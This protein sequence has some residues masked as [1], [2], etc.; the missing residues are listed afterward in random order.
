MPSVVLMLNVKAPQTT[1]SSP[2]SLDV[3]GWPGGIALAPLLPGE[4]EAEYAKLTARFLAAAKPRDFIEEI[5][6]RDAVDLSWEILR[7]RRQKAGLL[8]MACSAGVRSVAKELGFKGL[9]YDFAAKWMSGD[10]KTRKQFDEMLKKAGLGMED[11]TAEALSSKVDS[12]ERVDR[13]LASA[14]A[15]RNNAL[16]EIDRHREALCAAMRQ[17]IDEV[18]DAEFRD[19]ET[20]EVSRGSPS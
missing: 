7:L 1:S 13:I 20:G 16:R 5:L 11:V 4:S 2:G 6:A 17:A 15:R 18:Q 9:V 3:S 12:F 10:A 14:E 8:R 19:L